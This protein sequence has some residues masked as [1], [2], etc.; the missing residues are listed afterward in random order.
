MKLTQSKFR[1]NRS[2]FLQTERQ[3]AKIPLLENLL[4]SP[5]PSFKINFSYSVKS[6][7]DWTCTYQKS[8]IIRPLL[9][10][11][12]QVENVKIASQLSWSHLNYWPQI[13]AYASSWNK[14][15]VVFFF[16]SLESSN[17][18]DE[19]KIVKLY[20]GCSNQ[21]TMAGAAPWLSREKVC[22]CLPRS[23]M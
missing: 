21:T 8:R 17:T 3:F 7:N 5:N 16:S 19:H 6:E 11:P 22:R 12:E 23:S 9:T 20:F 15:D 13:L 1:R 10:R 18:G 14:F 2:I 4:A